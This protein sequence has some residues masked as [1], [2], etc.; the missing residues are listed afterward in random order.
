MCIQDE[1]EQYKKLQEQ[2]RENVKVRNYSEFLYY[3]PKLT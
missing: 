2:F 3:P 1:F